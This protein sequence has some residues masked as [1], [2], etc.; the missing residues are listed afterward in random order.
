MT[1]EDYIPT[2]QDKSFDIINGK[3]GYHSDSKSPSLDDFNDWADYWRCRIGVNVIP[4]DT[5]NK[6]TYIK[7][8]EWQDKPIPEEQHNRWKNENAFSKGIAIIPGKVWHRE[9]KKGLYLIG[10]DADNLKAI[11]EICTRNGRSISLNELAQWTLVEQHSDDTN[12]VHIYVYSHRPFAKKSS[13]KTGNNDLIKQKIT[14]SNAIPA[15]EVKGQGQHGILFCSPSIHRNGQPY[16]IIGTKEPVVAD[17]F[18]KHIDKIC[19]KYGLK[20][21]DNSSNNCNGNGKSQSHKTPIQELFNTSIKV[22]QGERAVKILRIMDSLLRR[23]ARILSLEQIR[24]LAYNWNKEHCD[25]PLNDAEFEHQW[26]S[27]TEFIDIRIREQKKK[28]HN[29]NQYH[30]D[31]QQQREETNDDR[32]TRSQ[33][34]IKLAKANT[35]I[36]FKDQYGKAYARIQIKDHNEIINLESNKFKCFLSKLY[37]ENSNEKVAS[38]EAINDTIRLLQAE[39]LF[40]DNN[41]IPLNLRVALK[42]GAFYIDMTDDKYRSIKMTK[43]TSWKIVNDTPPLFI[44]YNQKPQVEPDRNYEPDIF[45]KFLDMTNIKDPQ[46][47]LLVKVYIPSL[48]IPDIQHPILLL[49]GEPNSAK[50]TL[51]VMIKQ[52]VD[53]AKPK[54][55]SI[56]NDRSE[57]IQQLSHNYVAYY[58]N[59]KHVPEWLSD[60]A[61]KAVTGIGHTKRKLYSDDEDI[62]YEY[63]RCLGFNGINVSLIEPDALDRSILIELFRIPKEKRKTESEIMAKFEEM[64]PKL[65]GCILEIMVKALNIKHAVKL[66][67]LP[68]MTDFALWGEALAR[69]M[70]YEEMEFINAYFNN[71]G[72]QNIEAIEAHP[73]GLAMIKLTESIENN[74]GKTVWEG[75]ATELLDLLDKI[76]SQKVKNQHLW[77]KAPNSLVRKLNTI[78]SNLLEGLGISVTISRNTTGKNKNT[79]T[80]KIEKISPLSPPSPPGQN[81]TQNEERISGG[82]SGSGDTTSTIQQKPPPETGQNHGQ[83]SDSGG[84]GDGGGSI[85]N[86]EGERLLQPSLLPSTYVAFD[87]EWSSSNNATEQTSVSIENQITGAGFVDNQ[88][89]SKVLHITDFSN[90]DNAE[91]ELLV[92]INQE[93]IKYDFSIGWYS[94]GVAKYH[95]DTQEYIDGVDSDLAVLH[96]RCLANGVDSIVDFNSAGIPYIRGQKHIDLYNVFGKPLVQ[97]TI[98]KNTYRTLKLEEVSKAV[99]ADRSIEAEERGKYKGLTGKVIQS[100]PVEEQKKY[101]LRDAELVMQLSKHNNGEVLDSMKSISEITGLDFE[102]VCRTGISTWWAAIFDNMVMNGECQTRSASFDTTEEYKQE[103]IGGIVL[104]PRKGLYHNLIVVDVTSLYPTM[105]I[106]YNISF[107]TVNCECC[108]DN[109][110]CRINEEITKDCRIEKEYW[111]CREKQGAFP[112][113][114]RI[115]KEERLKQKNLGNQVKQLALKILINGGYGVFGNKYFKYYDPR[116]A[117]LITAYGRYTLTRMQEIARN[118]GFEIVYGDTDSLFLYNKSYDS[119]GDTPMRETISGF[120]IECSKQLGIEVEHSRTYKTAII[121]DKKKHYIGWTGVQGKEPD[122]V[123]MEGDKNDRPKWINNAFRQTIYDIVVHNIDPTVNL[124]KAIYDLEIGNVNSE[125]LKRSQKLSKNPEEYENENDRKRKIGS[126]V[127]ARKGNIIEYFESDSKEGYSLNPQDIS[128]RKYKIMLWKAVKDILEIAGYDIASMEQEL[129]L[130]IHD[131]TAK[132]PRMAWSGTANLQQGGELV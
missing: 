21:L 36:F 35:E 74:K 68:R 8:S 11:E 15:I 94:T 64:Q 122:I 31:G 37:Y 53:P 65:F 44:R 128:V 1:T 123:G 59:V 98:F 80:I 54:L 104:Q 25:P 87:F 115:F 119:N 101:V 131:H 92:S 114:L 41:T 81:Y 10:I 77:P 105:A 62:V 111:I 78:K 58:D 120:Q 127:G 55:L 40:E 48:F 76:T 66:D 117:E 6:S 30:I 5:K 3:E 60:E 106:L 116:V 109:S 84:S 49:H 96:N 112:Q 90:S 9:N 28:E 85:H 70:G 19:R 110:N 13:D 113:K 46:H 132:P 18:E 83:K 97:T 29:E 14:D 130:N 89:N 100:L 95:E 91:R 88:G 63:R 47:R 67:T 79:S 43:D 50:T 69:A 27:A 33:I 125:L 57:F 71:I 103:Y 16:Q 52:I 12:K 51:Y 126:V 26:K 129:I 102:R 7:W 32:E 4:A 73:L 108:K 99:L 45:D 24:A 72:K 56:H 38:Q 39:T 93:L 82:I 124:K 75:S 121:S 23:N 42:D 2:V 61:C 20:Y 118:M 86:L 34:L 107:D 22:L 17:D